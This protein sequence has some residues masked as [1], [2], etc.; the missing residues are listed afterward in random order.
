MRNK[1]FLS[2][3]RSDSM[4]TTSRI[5][6][7]LVKRY[8]KAAVFKDLDSISLAAQFQQVI[9]QAIPQS[10]VLMV[11]I[12]RSWVYATDEHGRR[13]LD[14]P[15]DFV[16]KE[17]ETALRF[18]IPLLPLLVDG[19]QMPKREQLPPSL[20]PLVYFN[21]LEVPNDPYF[22]ASMR[23]L[24]Q[25][26]DRYLPRGMRPVVRLRRAI[27]VGSAVVLV[28]SLLGGFA[29]HQITQP[30]AA[31]PLVSYTGHATLNSIVL[32]A[33]TDGWAVGTG[34]TILHY[35]QGIWDQVVSPTHANLN[36][37]AFTSDGEGWAV[38]DGGV[39]LQYSNNQWTIYTQSPTTTTLWSVSPAGW[40]VGDNGTILQLTSQQ[41][42]TNITLALPTAMALRGVFFPTPEDGWAVGDGGIILHYQPGTQWQPATS[43]GVGSTNLDLRGL[44]GSP[45]GS[46]SQCDI[47]SDCDGL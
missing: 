23:R 22:D 9:D 44:E 31:A 41:T 18:R 30:V 42:W 6:E 8:G 16:R 28:L 35:T 34:G 20:Q 10:V 24:G 7:R 5:Y 38:G 26:V 12:G 17:I 2:Y 43:T 47:A 39:M 37:V 45:I 19:A 21:A 11:V 46:G 14:Q 3:R 15:D 1:I 25:H 40:A 29:V 33:P 32:R 27:V 36:S 4:S 13:R